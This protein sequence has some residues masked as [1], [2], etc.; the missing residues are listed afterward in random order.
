MSQDAKDAIERLENFTVGKGFKLD[1]RPS[2][3]EDEPEDE[4]SATEPD[5][6]AVGRAVVAR[7]RIA[8]QAADVR[9]LVGG[10]PPVETAAAQDR[11]ARQLAPRSDSRLDTATYFDG[12]TAELLDYSTSVRC[13]GSRSVHT[14]PDGETQTF[15]LSSPTFVVGTTLLTRNGITIETYNDASVDDTGRSAHWASIGATL[16]D[17]AF[18]SG[19]SY[20]LE[21]ADYYGDTVKGGSAYGDLTGSGPSFSG[22]WRGMATAVTKQNDDLLLGDAELRYSFSASGGSLSATLGSFVSVTDARATTPLGIFFED[23]QVDS[24]GT[25]A[26][27][28]LGRNIRGAFYGNAHA[29][30][31]GVFEGTIPDGLGDSLDLL[32]AFGTKRQ[33]Q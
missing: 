19:Y 12:H 20:K 8:R 33:G 1:P 28:Y 13:S 23:V 21:N 10:S 11:R 7:D 2:P 17:S 30:A 6:E 18:F 26:S 15:D 3:D 31:T 32:G 4:A 5:A 25:F 27:G 29:E 22:T 16:H 14:H 9:R 24:D